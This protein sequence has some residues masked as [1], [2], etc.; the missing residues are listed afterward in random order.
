MYHYKY[1]KPNLRLFLMYRALI[2][3]L[4]MLKLVI[5]KGIG[6]VLNEL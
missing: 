5:S 1:K 3:V 2:N 6:D 4:N